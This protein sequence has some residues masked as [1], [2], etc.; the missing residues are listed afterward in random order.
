MLEAI[1]FTQAH[2]SALSVDTLLLVAGDDH[3]VDASGSAD[4]F[5]KCRRA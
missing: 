4:F 5:S 2:A 3:L 1:E